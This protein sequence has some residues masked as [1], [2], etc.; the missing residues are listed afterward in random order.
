MKNERFKIVISGT[1]YV[2][3]VA[4]VRFAEVAHQVICVDVDEQKMN[5]LK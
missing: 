4:G 1:V 2:D 3:L 5:L